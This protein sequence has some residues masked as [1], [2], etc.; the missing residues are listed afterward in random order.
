MPPEC[1]IMIK[2]E[3]LHHFLTHTHKPCAK[4]S[5][6]A[7]LSVLP[8][9]CPKPSLQSQWISMFWALRLYKYHLRGQ[10][11]CRTIVASPSRLSLI[12]SGFSRPHVSSLT[13]RCLMIQWDACWPGLAG[14]PLDWN[15]TCGWKYGLIVMVAHSKNIRLRNSAAGL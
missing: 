13:S 14:T 9:H 3:L 15:L 12:A 4:K 1:Q 2:A 5:D 6:S 10:Q 7:F 11:Q 8:P